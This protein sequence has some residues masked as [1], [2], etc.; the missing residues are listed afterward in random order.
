M[1]LTLRK[2][3]CR[4]GR[5]TLRFSKELD[6]LEESCH[7]FRA[8]YNFCRP[9]TSLGDSRGRMTPA[10]ELRLVDRVWS[11]RELMSFLHRQISVN[12]EYRTKN[13][14]LESLSNYLDFFR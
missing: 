6:R 1:N 3:L 11:L 12:Y 7:T 4:L 13:H 9:H 2:C 5:R 10:M 14:V 8:I